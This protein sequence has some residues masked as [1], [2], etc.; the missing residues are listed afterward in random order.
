MFEPMVSNAFFLR[1][2]RLPAGT[3]HSIEAAIRPE[4]VVLAVRDRA[5]SGVAQEHLDRVL[6]CHSVPAVELH[7]HG[8]DLERRVRA[9]DLRRDGVIEACGL[10]SRKP[11]DVVDVNFARERVR[12]SN[13]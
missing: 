4:V 8:G 13:Q 9:K 1:F 2:V 7:R 3:S 11:G 12:G 6:A 5:G 10:A